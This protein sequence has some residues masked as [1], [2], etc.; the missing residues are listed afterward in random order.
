VTVTLSP[1]LHLDSFRDQ[2]TSQS[3]QNTEW[4]SAQFGTN[5]LDPISFTVILPAGDWRLVL[6][7]EMPPNPPN[8]TSYSNELYDGSFNLVPLPAN[9]PELANLSTTNGQASFTVRSTAGN[10]NVVQCSTNLSDWF[11]ISTNVVPAENVFA[12]TDTNT[13]GSPARFYRVMQ[14]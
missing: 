3:G 11:A 6:F 10:T 4:A 13:G 5:A 8:Y 9:P 1:E 2:L 12:F 7:G 14:P